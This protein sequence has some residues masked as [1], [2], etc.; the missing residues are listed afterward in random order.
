MTFSASARKARGAFFTPLE[1]SRFLV[2]W[3][4]RS[5]SDRVLEPSCGDAMFLMP[6]AARLAAMGASTKQI[7]GLLSGVEIDQ[8]SVLEAEARLRSEGYSADIANRDFF[9]QEPEPS[10]DAVVG[11]PPFIR[12]Q[13]FSGSARAN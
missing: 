5:P 3:A 2:D 6:A 1:I 9:D 8:P 12:Y 4:V 13:N 7:G 11:N 10:F